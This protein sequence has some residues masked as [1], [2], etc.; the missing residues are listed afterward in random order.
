MGMRQRLGIAR[1]SLRPG[2]LILDEPTKGLDPGGMLEFRTL[3][4]ELVE[5]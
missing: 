1:C 4:R 5:D 2:L 3:V